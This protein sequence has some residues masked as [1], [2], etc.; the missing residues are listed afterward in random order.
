MTALPTVDDRFCAYHGCNG[1]KVRG[2][3]AI[4]YRPSSNDKRCQLAIRRCSSDD[5][6]GSFRETQAFG[7]RGKYGCK[8]ET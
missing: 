3:K 1:T 4:G 6:A 8:A 5:S 2:S 7:F